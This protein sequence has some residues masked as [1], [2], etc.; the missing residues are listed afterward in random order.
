MFAAE[1]HFVPHPDCDRQM[2]LDTVE[3]YLTALRENGQ[4]CGEAVS[5]WWRGAL[6][7]IVY[8]A[9]TDAL[10]DAQHSEAGRALR[11]EAADLC[12]EPPTWEITDDD[13][14]DA[15]DVVDW[16]HESALYLYTH[17]FLH[18]SCV[19]CGSSGRPVPAYRLPLT[20]EQ[21]RELHYWAAAYRQYERVWLDSS[22]LETPAF[23]QLSDARSDL[24]T[25]GRKL[26]QIIEA[27]TEVPTFYSL[28]YYADQKE[29]QRVQ[30]CPDCGANWFGGEKH[31][32]SPEDG[33]EWFDF[34]CDRCRL[35]LFA[36]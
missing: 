35:V 28:D 30:R 13:A 18:T 2:L 17:A 32:R 31:G 14:E 9:A 34:R 5:G 6:R 3:R 20:D 15:V 21:R 7:V 33:I 27:A 22:E 29:R 25:R 19:R 36:L 16:R 12:A 8:A 11:D 23:Q 4:L 1:G 26:C 10:G 24:A